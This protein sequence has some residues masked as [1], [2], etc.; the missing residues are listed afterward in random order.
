[1]SKEETLKEACDGALESIQKSFDIMDRGVSQHN[2][3][4]AEIWLNNTKANLQEA[5]GLDN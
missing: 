4:N 2:W 5:L 1:M 3:D